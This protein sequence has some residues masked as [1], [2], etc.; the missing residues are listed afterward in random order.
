[1]VFKI[2]YNKPL[3]KSNEKPQ[4]VILKSS[5]SIKNELLS[6]IHPIRRWC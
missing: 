2:S 6:G 1:M 3:I 5:E 4:P